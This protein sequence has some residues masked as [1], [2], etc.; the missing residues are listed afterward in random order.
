MMNPLFTLRLEPGLGLDLGTVYRKAVDLSLKLDVGI[1]FTFNDTSVLVYGASF[2]ATKMEGQQC[3]PDP[4]IM[5]E[6][7]YC[8]QTF[9]EADRRRALNKL[10][11]LEAHTE[12][13]L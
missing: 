9:A 10:P 8:R 2:Y 12:P 6:L 11:L 3:V 4:A 5:Q 13:N 7:H 1:R